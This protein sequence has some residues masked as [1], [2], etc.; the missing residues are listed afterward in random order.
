MVAGVC[1]ERRIVLLLNLILVGFCFYFSVTDIRYRI[2]P[3]RVVYPLLGTILIW[4]LL[5]EPSFLWGLIPALILFVLFWISPHSIGPG[6]VKLVAIIGLFV[7]LEQTLLTLFLMCLSYVAYAILLMSFKKKVDK[8]IP[9]APFV[10]VGILL[11]LMS[12]ARITIFG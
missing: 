3:N 5:M 9:L 12:H 8:R 4:R 2:I 1:I 7:G 10:T 11:M 6:D